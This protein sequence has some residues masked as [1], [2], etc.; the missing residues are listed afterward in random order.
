MH[1]DPSGDSLNHSD[2]DV[3]AYTNAIIKGSKFVEVDKSKGDLMKTEEENTRNPYFMA[4][5]RD[6]IIEAHKI[7]V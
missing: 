7:A 4:M 2:K 1:Y 3:T 5:D 6:E